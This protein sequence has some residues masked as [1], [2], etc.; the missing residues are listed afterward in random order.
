MCV[1]FATDILLFATD[2]LHQSLS[3]IF[4]LGSVDRFEEVSKF[5][6]FWYVGLE[7]LLQIG[8]VV[9]EEWINE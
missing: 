2:I 5:M 8:L 9:W 7:L 6:R 3:V 4:V 1:C